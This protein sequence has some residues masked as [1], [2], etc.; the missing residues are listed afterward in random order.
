MDPERQFPHSGRGNELKRLAPVLSWIL[1]CAMLL[2]AVQEIRRER[3]LTD[4][5]LVMGEIP[6]PTVKV[7]PLVLDDYRAIQK[8]TLVF[9]S[10]EIV[11]RQDGLV[12]SATSLADYAAW[13]LTVDQVLLDNPKVVWSIDYLCSGKCPAGESHRAALNGRRSAPTI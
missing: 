5:S 11:A 3:R 12:V 6:R 10:V 7:V 8:K 2:G 1:A 4:V 13:R 9:G